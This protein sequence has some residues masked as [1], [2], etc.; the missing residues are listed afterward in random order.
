MTIHEHV[1]REWDIVSAAKDGRQKFTAF[2]NDPKADNPRLDDEQREAVC[3]ILSSPDFITLFRGGAGTGK[4]FTLR[5]VQRVLQASGHSVQVVAPQRQQVIGLERD[6]F[7]NVQTV[8]ALLARHDL[9]RDSLRA[10]DE[11]GIL[12]ANKCTLFCAAQE[13]HARVILSGHSTRD[14]GSGRGVRCVSGPLRKYA[15]KPSGQ[16]NIRSARIRLVPIP[17]QV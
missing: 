13:N 16:T 7:A 3:R 5:E 17:E 1:R 15:P 12:A 14:T 9:P 11:A 8:S 6:G 4:S 10:V 2:S